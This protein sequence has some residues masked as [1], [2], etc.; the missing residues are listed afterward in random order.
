[1]SRESSRAALDSWLVKWGG[2]RGAMAGSGRE[3][4]LAM[5]AILEERQPTEQQLTG[6]AAAEPI[7]PS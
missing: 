1:M 2:A 6:L 7:M 5:R 3:G 4:Y